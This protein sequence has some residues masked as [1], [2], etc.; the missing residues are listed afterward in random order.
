MIRL[1]VESSFRSQISGIERLGIELKISV[2]FRSAKVAR[3]KSRPVRLATFAERKA[4][5]RNTSMLAASHCRVTLPTFLSAAP[6]V[7]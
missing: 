5:I 4:T 3:V 6:V 2:A 7:W 1:I